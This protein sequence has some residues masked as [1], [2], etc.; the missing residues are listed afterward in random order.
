MMKTM[1]TIAS[2]SETDYSGIQAQS[3]CVG[4]FLSSSSMYRFQI[5]RSLRVFSKTKTP[6]CLHDHNFTNYPTWWSESLEFTV[7]SSTLTRF[8]TGQDF[9]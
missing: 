2:F 4:I 3:A 7:L 1:T 6:I 8:P 5:S 9:E